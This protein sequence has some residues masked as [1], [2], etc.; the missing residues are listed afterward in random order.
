MDQDQD[1]GTNRT[2][3]HYTLLY[4]GLYVLRESNLVPEVDGVDGVEGPVVILSTGV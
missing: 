2:R 1:E 4:L 3:S